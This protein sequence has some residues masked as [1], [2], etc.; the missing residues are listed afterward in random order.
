MNNQSNSKRKMIPSLPLLS[1]EPS[2]S[3]KENP[4]KKGNI[5]YFFSK[6]KVLDVFEYVQLK[7]ALHEADK[8]A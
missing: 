3:K 6:L 7:A 4:N 1:C 2:M 8:T 5:T